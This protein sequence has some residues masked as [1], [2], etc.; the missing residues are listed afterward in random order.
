[1]EE[2]TFDSQSKWKQSLACVWTTFRYVL[3]AAGYNP[4]CFC[5]WDLVSF[6]RSY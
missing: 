5:S 2:N 4:L 1:V 3:L 6:L